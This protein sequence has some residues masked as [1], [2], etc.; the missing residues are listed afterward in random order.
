[1]GFEAGRGSAVL[2]DAAAQ[3]LSERVTDGFAL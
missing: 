2:Q 1:M 3:D